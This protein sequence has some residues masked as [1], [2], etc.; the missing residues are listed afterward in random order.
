MMNDCRF[1]VFRLRSARVRVHVLFTSAAYYSRMTTLNMSSRLAAGTTGA[2]VLSICLAFSG[3]PAIAGVASTH[4]SLGNAMPTSATQDVLAQN[5][6]A[7]ETNDSRSDLARLFKVEDAAEAIA[8][9][10]KTGPRAAA[11]ARQAAAL[12]PTVRS[13]L[14]QN[15][16]TASELAA[17]DAAIAALRNDLSSHAD[18]ARDANEVTGALAPLFTR[19]GDKVPAGVH[20]L[21]YLGRSIKLDVRGGDWARAQRE[22]RVLQSRWTAVR[23]QVDARHGGKAAAAEFAHA[24]GAVASGVSA[25]SGE[26]ALS[27]TTQIGN[28]VDSIEKVF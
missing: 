7:A 8:E 26:S 25:R 11:G 1:A 12:W 28:A 13:S 2:A 14:G 21:D 19:A 24:S 4:Q 9:G 20:Y 3:P 5:G 18:L 10:E 6:E 23:A 22:V 17:A 16:S 27:A 15:G